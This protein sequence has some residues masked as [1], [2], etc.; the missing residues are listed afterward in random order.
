MTYKKSHKK[1]KANARKPKN[2]TKPGDVICPLKICFFL[3]PGQNRNDYRAIIS[4]DTKLSAA[5]ILDIYCQR[6]SIEIVFKD[7]KQNFGF[8]TFQATKYGTQIA[9]VT[10]RM[11]CYILMCYVKDKEPEK[12][13]LHAIQLTL[14]KE[15]ERQ[16]IAE[17][18]KKIMK[19]MIYLF[20]KFSVAQG[21]IDIKDV[22]ENYDYIS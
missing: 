15:Y 11:I 14:F 5:K 18:I 16:K 4:T 12:I 19:E 13:S 9:D 20:L 17:Y 1:K 3:F 10:L 2:Y 6:W 21:Y 22:I 8:N 7:L